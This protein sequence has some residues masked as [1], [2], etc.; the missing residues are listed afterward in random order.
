MADDRHYVPGDF[1]RIC[2]RTGFKMRA[3]K[4]RQ[5]WTH[6]IV[7]DQSFEE[8]QPQDFVRGVYDNQ[9]VPLPRPRQP[10]RFINPNLVPAGEFQVYG[11]NP[12]GPGPSFLVQN[13]QGPSYNPGLNSSNTNPS[14]GASMQEI[15]GT[16]PAVRPEDYP[17]SNGSGFG[18]GA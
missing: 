11:D 3:G 18:G 10:D 5:E 15:N 12:S 16:V 9:N 1:Y 7:R 6:N 13:E 8:R 17:P 2:D 4:T 14:G